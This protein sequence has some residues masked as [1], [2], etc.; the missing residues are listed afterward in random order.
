M[1][2]AVRKEPVER[3]RNRAYA[4]EQIPRRIFDAPL[5]KVANGRFQSR[6]AVRG[7]VTRCCLATHGSS[8]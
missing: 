3:P 7:A 5:R 6:E 4:R 2:R 8:G 1:D